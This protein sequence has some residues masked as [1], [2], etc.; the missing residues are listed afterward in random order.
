MTA[1]TL[2]VVSV[3][4]LIFRY[5][6]AGITLTVSPQCKVLEHHPRIMGAD[7]D[8][9]FQGNCVHTIMIFLE[10]TAAICLDLEVPSTSRDMNFV[11]AI[12]L[13]HIICLRCKD[14]RTATGQ[15]ATLPCGPPLYSPF[16]QTH[17]S[18]EGQ[19][20]SPHRHAIAIA[21][22]PNTRTRTQHSHRH[23]RIT[24]G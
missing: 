8:L 13:E 10:E 16:A 15:T 7:P 21:S 18:C 20:Y 14:L 24:V 19:T 12:C 2:V 23:R 11:K 9:A 6:T 17:I 4:D 3:A 5:S 1:S 22:L